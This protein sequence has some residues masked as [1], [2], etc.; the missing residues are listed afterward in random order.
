[1]NTYKEMRIVPGTNESCVITITPNVS[2]LKCQC[3]LS[4]YFV[5][6]ILCVTETY[7]FLLALNTGSESV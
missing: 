4:I 5:R 6:G 2:K 1:M 7:S 3:F